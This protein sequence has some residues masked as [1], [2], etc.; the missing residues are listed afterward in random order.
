MAMNYGRILYGEKDLS[1][2][3][4]KLRHAF[5]T[6]QLHLPRPE[7]IKSHFFKTENFL[8]INKQA[9]WTVALLHVTT[10]DYCAG[11]PAAAP[12]GRWFSDGTQQVKL[13][14]EF[15]DLQGFLQPKWFI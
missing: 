3:Q 13:V 4:G 9:K 10:E 6:L 8:A 5:S 1:E 7:K 15:K 11:T 12:Q 2:K 14:V